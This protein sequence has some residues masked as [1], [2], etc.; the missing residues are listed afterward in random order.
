MEVVVYFEVLAMGELIVGLA[1]ML[2]L[3]EGEL[4]MELAEA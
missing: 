4:K 2:V 3:A 1:M